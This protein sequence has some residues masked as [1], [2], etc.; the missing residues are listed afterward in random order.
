MYFFI[1][2]SDLILSHI[3]TFGSNLLQIIPQLN[4]SWLKLLIQLVIPRDTI[5]IAIII[6][7]YLWYLYEISTIVHNILFELDQFMQKV[8]EQVFKIKTSYLVPDRK[9]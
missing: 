2:D 9:Q 3:S 8:N 5:L 6:C 7:F 4:G 1:T